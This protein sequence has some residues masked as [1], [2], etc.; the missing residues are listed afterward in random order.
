[1]I[2]S[3]SAH[4]RLGAIPQNG[5]MEGSFVIRPHP[6]PNVEIVL[7]AD[8]RGL[9]ELTPYGEAG[10]GQAWQYRIRTTRTGV[11]T[12]TG[13]IGGSEGRA[14][15]R[16]GFEIKSAEAFESQ[17]LFLPSP[18]EFCSD[19]LLRQNIRLMTEELRCGVNASMSPVT[20]LRGY[21]TVVLHGDGAL[22]MS[23]IQ[24]RIYQDYIA[25]GGRLVVLANKFVSDSISAS[26]ELT[27][28][29]GI[30]LED[31]ELDVVI[32]GSDCIRDCSVTDGVQ[33]LYW[34]RPSPVVVRGPARVL[35][36]FPGLSEK[37]V[38]GSGGTQG[39]VFVAGHSLLSSFVCIGW[40]FD[41]GRLLANLLCRQ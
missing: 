8:S 27:R 26:N 3:Y 34:F 16:I 20:E 18:Y 12:A 25:S 4:V 24:R 31:N 19:A 14:G 1:M 38:L 5:V 22:G 40:P 30:E 23:G 37:G 13:E 35:V 15:F 2:E 21:Q 11:F 9:V 28:D 39:N 33:K 29:Y 7:G 17:V 32:C 41:N 6:G 36:A 10:S